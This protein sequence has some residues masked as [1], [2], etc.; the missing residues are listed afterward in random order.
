VKLDLKSS[1]ALNEQSVETVVKEVKGVV[2]I[3]LD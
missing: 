2:K 3:E 1:Q